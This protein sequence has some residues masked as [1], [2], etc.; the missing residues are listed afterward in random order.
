MALTLAQYN[1]T[2]T[3]QEPGPQPRPLATFIML[4]SPASRLMDAINL[5]VQCCGVRVLRTVT[6][7]VTKVRTVTGVVAP[8]CRRRCRISIRE[9][10]T[11]NTDLWERVATTEMRLRNMW[12]MSKIRFATRIR[13]HIRCR[14]CRSGSSCSRHR[15]AI[16]KMARDEEAAAARGRA[17]LSGGREVEYNDEAAN[18]IDESRQFSGM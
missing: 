13:Q 12:R 8:S 1:S 15:A 18:L 14:C 6:T 11:N 10:H 16:W 17:I 4:L 3:R 5:L 9:R 7:I 2:K